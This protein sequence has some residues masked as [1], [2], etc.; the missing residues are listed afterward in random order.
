MQNEN[1]SKLVLFIAALT[2]AL[3]V[4]LGAI[5]AHAMESKV[6]ASIFKTANQY[7]FYHVFALI[8]IGYEIRNNFSFA[9]KISLT[10]MVAGLMFFCGSLYA[11]AFTGSSTFS[12]LAPIGG[13]S[14]IIAWFALAWA[15]LSRS[16]S[17]TEE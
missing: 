2:G 7:H 15:F 3:A 10:G 5:G 9:L 6:Y 1:Y 4:I 8:V 16:R 17:T 12:H 14:F 11:K 13:S